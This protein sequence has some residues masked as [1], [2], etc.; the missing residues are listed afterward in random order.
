[1]EVRPPKQLFSSLQQPYHIPPADEN[2]SSALDTAVKIVLPLREA[3]LPNMISTTEVYPLPDSEDEQQEEEESLR[4][5]ETSFRA[6]TH[7]LLQISPSEVCSGPRQAKATALSTFAPQETSETQ[8]ESLSVV[9][10]HQ[11]LS[12]GFWLGYG[13]VDMP[14]GT[15]ITNS[16]T[17]KQAA[18]VEYGRIS[19]TAIRSN[20]GCSP[21]GKGRRIYFE[22][23]L[24]QFCT[25]SR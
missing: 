7:T 12:S 3:N 11:N 9:C 4:L 20:S 25:H 1:M 8:T 2:G 14:K 6:P 19:A 23:C 21:T 24:F 16:K 22:T 13:G 10:A 15:D 5:S 17:E 18:R